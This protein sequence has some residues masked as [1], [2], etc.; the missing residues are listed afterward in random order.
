MSEFANRAAGALEQAASYTAGLLRVL[1]E[2]DPLDVLRETPGKFRRSAESV[3]LERLNVP[4]ALGK[5]SM[6]Q[7]LMHLQ[8]S[9]LVG[10]HR[11]RMAL[12]EDRPPIIG[13]DQDRWVARLHPSSA[14]AA[15][16]EV[17]LDVFEIVRRANVRLLE[18]LSPADFARIG[19]HA[20]RGEESV[21]HMMRLYAGHDLVHLRQLD[22][23][24]AAV[25]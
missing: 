16:V 1:G 6:A 8:D 22:R 17:C 13:Y 21:A 12:A 15:E 5:W 18:G 11:Y 10:A 4:E 24:R 7:V 9:E 3:S 2:R 20:E 25:A 23:I 14:D 19:L